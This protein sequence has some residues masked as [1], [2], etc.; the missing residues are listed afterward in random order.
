MNCCGNHHNNNNNNHEKPPKN[1]KPH[2]AHVHPM[3]MMA[4]CCGAPIIMLAAISLLGSIS[5]GTK[6][7]LLSIVPYICPIMM[8]VMIPM[9]FFT[10][11]KSKNSCDGATDAQQIKESS[12]DK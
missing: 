12:E 6:T 3:W 4:L 1:K 10:N 5:P 2:G 9:M 8:L 7:F 11:K